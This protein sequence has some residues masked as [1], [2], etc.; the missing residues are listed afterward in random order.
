MPVLRGRGSVWWR[1]QTVTLGDRGRRSL[2]I[3]SN[4]KTQQIHTRHNNSVYVFQPFVQPIVEC[5]LYKLR[6]PA[7]VS[8]HLAQLDPDSS[9][10]GWGRGLRLT[11]IK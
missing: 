1:A 7:N 6:I 8:C 11:D 2:H 4:T 10:H 5:T 9:S 3:H